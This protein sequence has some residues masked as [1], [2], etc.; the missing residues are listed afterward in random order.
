MENMPLY[1]KI[2]MPLQFGD[3]VRRSCN[4]ACETYHGMSFFA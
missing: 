3:G 1:V 4:N 2:N